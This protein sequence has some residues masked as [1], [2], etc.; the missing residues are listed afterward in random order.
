MLSLSVVLNSGTVDT[1][2]NIQTHVSPEEV[3]L[4]LQRKKDGK[5]CPPGQ[6]NSLI[7][8]PFQLA[9]TFQSCYS[10]RRDPYLKPV[11]L[12]FGDCLTQVSKVSRLV[13]SKGTKTDSGH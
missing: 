10:K 5:P 6:L 11:P 3:A 7:I 2:S 12:Y 4:W 1:K 9:R 8:V 13:V